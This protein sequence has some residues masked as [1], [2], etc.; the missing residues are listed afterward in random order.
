MKLRTD[1]F[2]RPLATFTVW[3][4]ADVWQRFRA[5]CLDQAQTPTQS[6][7]SH[8]ERTVRRHEARTKKPPAKVAAAGGAR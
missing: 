8:V 4:S 7:R 5:V 2:G 6:I 1:K 3:F